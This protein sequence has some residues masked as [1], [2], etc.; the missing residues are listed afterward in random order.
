MD[1]LFRRRRSDVVAG[2][3]HAACVWSGDFS[4]TPGHG[5]PHALRVS[6]SKRGLRHIHTTNSEAATWAE[7]VIEAAFL[8]SLVDAVLEVETAC[9][10][11]CW[12]GPNE[13]SMRERLFHAAQVQ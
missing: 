13:V 12:D 4:R 3:D 7:E 5:R 8:K 2:C 11:N 10:G 9:V 6:R 1:G